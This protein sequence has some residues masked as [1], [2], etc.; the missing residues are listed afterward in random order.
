MRNKKEYFIF[1][2]QDIREF[3]FHR[4][5]IPDLGVMISGKFDLNHVVHASKDHYKKD[6][7]EAIVKEAGLYILR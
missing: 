1:A 2:K 4:Y 5:L 6:E 7:F 3:K